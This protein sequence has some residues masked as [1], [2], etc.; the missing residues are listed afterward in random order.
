V[1]QKSIIFLSQA[2]SGVQRFKLKRENFGRNM[3]GSGGERNTT[4]GEEIIETIKKSNEAKRKGSPGGTIILR[5]RKWKH[6]GQT[7]RR[8][9][10][11]RAERLHI[12]RES[13]K[14]K[15]RV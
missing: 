9:R 5:G 14:S 13:G 2:K 15:V 1:K 7:R 6:L 10:R 4:T 8:F 3:A 12:A 11:V